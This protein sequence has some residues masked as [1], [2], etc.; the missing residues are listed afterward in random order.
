AA[1]KWEEAELHDQ[2]KVWIDVAERT[3]VRL[4]LDVL[5]DR[6]LV[7]K[8]S[9]VDVEWARINNEVWML[10]HCFMRF[11]APHGEKV[12]DRSEFDV[13]SRVLPGPVVLA[14]AEKAASSPAPNIQPPEEATVRSIV[15]KGFDAYQRGDFRAL[16]ALF[17]Q[18]SPHLLAGKVDIENNSAYYGKDEI[19]NLNV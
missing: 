9:S 16:F 18:E 12:V 8:G 4:H 17:S 7:S 11:P 3:V 5:S 10:T 2:V 14:P 15:Q 19:K 6:P 1:D 13:T